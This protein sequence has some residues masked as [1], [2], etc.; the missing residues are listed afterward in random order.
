M[1]VIMQTSL[2]KNF[3]ENSS[4][5]F[6]YFRII[7]NPQDQTE[8]LCLLDMNRSFENIIGYK[9]EAISGKS[10]IRQFPSLK[11]KILEITDTCKN[12]ENEYREIKTSMALLDKHLNIQISKSA[13]S[14]Y[15]ALVFDVTPDMTI[16]RKLDES[17]ERYRALFENAGDSITIMYQNR[18][19][20]CNSRSLELFGLKEKEELIGHTPEEFSPVLQPNGIRS[21]E[22]I[23]S[24]IRKTYEGRQQRFSW[25]HIKKD[26]QPFDTDITLNRISINGKY[27]L[28]AILRDI[29]EKLIAD[30]EMKREKELLKAVFDNVP[31]GFIVLGKNG[32]FLNVNHEYEKISGYK[33]GEI[34]SVEQWFH[35]VY[36]DK[37]YRNH[38]LNKWGCDKEKTVASREFHITTKQGQQKEID[39]RAAFLQDG[40]SIVTLTDITEELRHQNEL[41]DLKNKLQLALEAGNTGVWEYDFTEE[42]MHWEKSMF[43]LYEVGPEEFSGKISFFDTI[44]LKDDLIKDRKEIQAAIEKKKPYSSEFRIKTPK[45]TLKYIKAKGKTI[46]DEAG[47]PLKIIGINYDITDI[48]IAE[49]AAIAANKAKSDFL[50]NIS[51]EIRTPMNGVIGFS[52]LMKDTPLNDEQS[53]YIKNVILSGKKMMRIINDILDFSKIEANKIELEMAKTNVY[54]LL[55][56][57]INSI[58]PKAYS[59]NIKL[60]LIKDDQLP[61][62]I[63]SDQ[64]RLSQIINNLLSNAVKF[65]AKGKI[66]LSAAIIRKVKKSIKIEF[67]V[68][69]TGIGIEKEKINKIFTPFTQ[70]DSSVTRKYGGTGLGLTISNSLAKLLG[71]PLKVESTKNVGSRF[72]FTV[73]AG[74]TIPEEKREEKSF[75]Q[76]LQILLVEDDPLNA[77]LLRKILLKSFPD[78]DMLSTE[79]GNKAYALYL[80]QQP[81]IIITDL[82]I[83]GSDGFTL[84]ERIRNYDDEIKIIAIPGDV[85]KET[86][87]KIFRAGMN[88]CL[89]K[90][91]SAKRLIEIIEKYKKGSAL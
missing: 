73:N 87:M 72:S 10:L 51:H 71:S 22:L 84:A 19:I 33:A 25:Q 68:Q 36:P 12:M 74:L 89:H 62:F 61:E 82:N 56:N 20:D 30:Q 18:F 1:E 43:N 28:Q 54:E 85:R 5:G 55:T 7:E 41:K 76:P 79:D 24:Y 4:T 38:V 34:K 59:K 60:E 29:T 81:D 57:S 35:T 3:F 66:T 37:T 39:Y 15:C 90:P 47:N 58:K 42:K 80:D 23:Q 31:L 16:E 2:Y 50:A 6:V 14:H 64:L 91:L 17:H 45:G 21:G 26:G 67:A 83:K 49:L 75:N 13:N 46:Y 8:D 44:M 32:E 88:D 53:E 65:T 63:I 77:K 78:A 70:E 52:E 40:R 11:E 27:Y 86:M 48:K 69:D 9:K